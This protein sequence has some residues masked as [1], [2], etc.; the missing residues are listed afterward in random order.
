MMVLAKMRRI[1]AGELATT[2]VDIAMPSLRT[3]RVLCSGR[4]S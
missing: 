2:G 4:D 3:T 1:R